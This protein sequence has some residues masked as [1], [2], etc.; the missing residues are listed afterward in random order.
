MDILGTEAE[1][2][3]H[4]FQLDIALDIGNSLTVTV[5]D[6]DK[7]YATTSAG[8]TGAKTYVINTNVPTAFITETLSIYSAI[9]EPSTVHAYMDKVPEPATLT[10]L[11]IGAV[12]LM[13]RR[14]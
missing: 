14:R 12:A 5:T 2:A 4:R 11:G 6:L 7:D 8:Y 1:L 13:R 10:L 9:G 3:M